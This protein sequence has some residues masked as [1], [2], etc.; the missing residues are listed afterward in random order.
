MKKY[1]VYKLTSPSNK[2]Y[3]GFTSL[4]LK[5]RFSLHKSNF[6]I[7]QKTDRK[8]GCTK[9]YYAF[10]KYGTLNWAKNIIGTY[11]TS[12]EALQQEMFYIQ[13]YNTMNEGYNITP[14]GDKANL[15]LLLSEEHKLNISITRKEYFKTPEGILWKQQLSEKFKNNNPSYKGMKSRVGHHTQESKDKISKANI[16]RVRTNEQ[17]RVM[18]ETN[19]KRWEDGVYT[20]RKPADRSNVIPRTGWKQSEHQ[21]QT[22]AKALS[23]DWEITDPEGNVFTITNL[24]QFCKDNNLGQANMSS[25]A[26]GRLKHYKKYK[27]RQI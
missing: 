19:K 17:R 26:A 20:N 9:L 14:G 27:V 12:E 11:N 5:Q 23:K 24:T 8:G 18:S 1:T 6:K 22:A 16:G 2:I 21:K 4:T 3:V 15:G 13:Q 25:V 7:W 10:E